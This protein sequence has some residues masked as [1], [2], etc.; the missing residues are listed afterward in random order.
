[1]KK[2]SILAVVAVVVLALGLGALGGY[3]AALAAPGNR[4]VDQLSGFRDSKPHIVSAT[5]LSQLAPVIGTSYWAGQR[6]DTEI[7]LTVTQAAIYVRYLPASAAPDSKK[8]VLTV[9]TYRDLDG[10][11]ALTS[12]AAAVKARSGAI[13]A[14]TASDPLSTYFAFPNSTFEVE[15]YSP[16]SGESRKL[17]NDGS[18]T[19]VPS[20]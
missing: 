16:M 4:A 8:P 5:T 20:R 3:V 15:V 1:M 18:V 11:G 13:I 12:Q 17:V 6:P 7:A 19:P 14:A 10:Y 2:R 9:A